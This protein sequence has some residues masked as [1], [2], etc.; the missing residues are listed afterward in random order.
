VGEKLLT[1]EKCAV[2]FYRVLV[3]GL[4]QSRVLCLDILLP[5]L[6]KDKIFKREH[7]KRPLAGAHAQHNIDGTGVT[8][9]SALVTPHSIIS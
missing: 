9:V 7:A 6:F 8:N 5:R 1:A 2:C 4:K 3:F